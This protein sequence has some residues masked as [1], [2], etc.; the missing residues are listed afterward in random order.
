[1]LKD[2][3]KL[4]MLLPSHMSNRLSFD[5][6]VLV[7]GC[8]S[9]AQAFLP[10]LEKHTTIPK[11]R[12]SILAADRIGDAA[13]REY[14]S[15]LIC[16]PLRPSNLSTIL[17]TLVKPG[18][19]IVNL[20]VNVSSLAVVEYAFHSGALYIDSANLL[21]P[22][23]SQD[24][25]TPLIQRSNYYYRQ[26][27]LQLRSRLRNGPTALIAHGA[28]PG[29]VQ[30]FLKQGLAN[31]AYDRGI[32]LPTDMDRNGWPRLAEQ[33][34]LRA[35]QITEHDS[36][37]SLR[38]RAPREFLNTW[39]P[40]VAYYGSIQ[41]TEIGWGTHE[42]TLPAGAVQ[43]G[44]EIPTIL[45]PRPGLRNLLRSWTPNG[46]PFIGFAIAHEEVVSLSDLLTIR[47]GD[48]IVYRPTTTF[49]YQPCDSAL[50]SMHEYSGNGF[51]LPQIRHILMSEI[52]DGRDE[53][54][55]LLMC[56]GGKSYWFG[57]LL[58]IHDARRRAPLNNATTMQVAAGVLAA[59]AWAIS[60]PRLGI[61]EPDD[62]D[63]L[64]ALDIAR[65]YL[66]P[67]VGTYTDWSPLDQ[68]EVLFSE[69]I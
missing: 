50:A 30:H 6:N 48:R 32:S 38:A 41:P 63:H 59:L 18:D 46:G 43:L 51:V 5:G 1:M 4:P 7:I 10:M 55:V 64:F 29:M 58:S 31:I 16:E 17:N 54:G 23:V 36:Q 68:R 3:E 25:N 67:I 2:Y 56:E 40:E 26:Q 66:E 21:W 65:Q 12:I 52:I 34:G 61:Q 13:A 37:R 47:R 44:P 19:I 28:N 60:H 45:I 69:P 9:I 14:A 33:L 62:I 53:L 11:S 42:R 49:V 35:L 8:G 27:M 57:S 39:S 15:R 24:I 22:D 20:S